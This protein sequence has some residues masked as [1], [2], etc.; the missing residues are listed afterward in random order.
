MRSQKV[1]FFGVKNGLFRKK[2]VLKR[3]LSQRH[4]CPR[5]SFCISSI[6]PCRT[7]WISTPFNEVIERNLTGC[8]AVCLNLCKLWFWYLKNGSSWV[9][10]FS[11]FSP[12]WDLN[13][14][15]SSIKPCRTVWISTPF[16]EVAS[17]NFFENA[18]SKSCIFG[19]KN[20]LFRK[21]IVT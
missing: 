1:A 10:F 17:Q 8:S 19:V 15:I 7:V 21:K 20:G 5:R 14:C 6:K 2:I 18:F 16:N 4:I 9:K 12:N 13:L 11:R 3:L